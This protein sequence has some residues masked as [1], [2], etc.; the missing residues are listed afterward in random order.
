MKQLIKNELI[1]LRAQKTYI[2]LSCVVLALVV[3]VSFFTSVLMTP[4]NNLIM[5]G[6]DMFVKS[7]A[8]DWA[9]DKIGQDPDSALAKILRV[10]F[11]DPKSDAEKAREEAQEYLE[12]GH[13]GMYAE[14]MAYAD[15][16]DFCDQNQVPAWVSQTVSYQ[17]VTAY[18]WRSVVKGLADGTYMASDLVKDYALSEVLYMNYRGYGDAYEEPAY[19]YEV[20]VTEWDEKTYEPKEYVFMRVSTEMYEE[21]QCTWAEVLGD[22]Y[23]HLEECEAYIAEIENYALTIEP[24]AYYDTLIAQCRQQIESKKDSIENYRAEI[25]ALE[26]EMKEEMQPWY[27][28]Q[29]NACYGEIEDNERIIAAYEDLKELDA[30]PESNS[31]LLVSRVLPGVLSARR[32][33]ITSIETN[34]AIDEFF[35]ISKAGE[36][37]SNH[38]IRV[39]D[40]ALIAIEYAYTRDILPEDLSASSA[41]ATFINNLSTASFLISAVT[42]VL[43]SM[44]LSREFATGTVRLWVIR[45]KTRNKLLGSKIATLLI[46]ICSMMGA[47]FVITYLFALANHLIDLFFYGQST[48]FAPSY[49]VLFGLTLPIPAVA[50][51]VWALIVL[52]LP[53]ILYAMLCLFVSVLTKKGVLSI[54]LGMLVLMFATDI[55]ALALI[56]ANY[57]GVFGYVL[58]ATALP[59]LS[60]DR[61]LVTALDFGISSATFGS[62][63]GLGAL[64]GLED[65]FM[66]Q[67]W[68]A[69][70]Y[71]CSSFVGAA[72]LIVHIVGLVWLSLFAFKRT[73]IKS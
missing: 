12:N 41:K 24:D 16:Y 63:D 28:A 23:D 2:I 44:I 6:D 54:V 37:S 5:H 58:Q 59:Y 45:P 39:L 7:A 61:L 8:Y 17:L 3:V 42:V 66:S 51:H 19:Y 11:K 26:P 33:A 31:F 32:D 55:Q 15:V 53:I 9:I 35:L 56:V 43:A 52:T 36:S 14:S 27:E 62:L 65:M 30:H 64:V 46:Y 50:E 40:K 10:V 60:M 34:V 18:K 13:L 25:E 1:K 48:L 20:Y 72:V 57:T 70:P 49:G 68:G 38:K 47:S 69:M 21:T 22:L 4:L 67:I 73:Q 71:V 29:I